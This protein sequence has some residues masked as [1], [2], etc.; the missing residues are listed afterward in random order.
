MSKHSSPSQD[1]FEFGNAC[2]KGGEGLIVQAYAK[3]AFTARQDDGSR[4]TTLARFGAYEVR[5]FEIWP[6]FSARPEFPYLWLELY[7]H[8]TK[9]VID[10]SG[11]SHFLPAGIAAQQLMG[12]AWQRHKGMAKS[13]GHL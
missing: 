6:E 5:L 10:S 3:L 9:D 12:E 13:F 11:H 2:P 1:E 4:Y 8:E 7:S